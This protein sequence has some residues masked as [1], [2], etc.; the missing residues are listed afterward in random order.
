MSDGAAL[1][2]AM[3]FAGQGS[4]EPAMGLSIAAA[5]GRARE[6]LD[7][8]S[9]C[10]GVSLA[11]EIERM[12]PALR[13]TDVLQPALVAVGLGVAS[14]FDEHAVRP[15]WTA[16]HS[17]GDLTAW[18]AAGGTSYECAVDLAHVRGDA[19]AS[20]ARAHPGA[21]IALTDIESDAVHA[22]VD[23][24]TSRA[25]DVWIAAHNGP[26][27]WVLTGDAVALRRVTAGLPATKLAVSGA[28][29]SAW[30]QPAAD[31]FATALAMQPTC[32]A[33]ATWL[34]CATATAVR[35]ED[36]AQTLS[37]ALV[38]PVR[39]VETLHALADL[40]ARHFVIA[41]PGR[42]LRASVRRT[43][44]ADVSVLLVDDVVSAD[45][46]RRAICNP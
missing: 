32:T 44:G 18:A 1:P 23:N 13:R 4:E 35:P 39:W 16:G 42:A 9:A 21:M 8:A 31:A 2:F 6:L 41:G 28:W 40:G 27:E 25:E 37:Q 26:R 34:S 14:W 22:L 19:M 38:R 11:R 3:L 17:L 24:A 45:A 30:M 43:L 46:A 36:A 10:T 20:V 12:G 7:R 33:R 5:C 29:H 15:S